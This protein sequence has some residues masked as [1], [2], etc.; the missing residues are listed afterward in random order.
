MHAVGL[1]I[2][3]L[4]MIM[5]TKEGIESFILVIEC[6]TLSCMSFIKPLTILNLIKMMDTCILIET[7]MKLSKNLYELKSFVLNDV[8]EGLL[9]WF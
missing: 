7:L 3:A 8:S 6:L 5:H 9:F 1:N 2:F 4:W